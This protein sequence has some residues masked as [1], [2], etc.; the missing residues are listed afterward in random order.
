LRR[1]EIRGVFLFLALIIILRV[2]TSFAVPADNTSFEVRNVK[3]VGVNEVDKEELAKSLMAKVPSFW[4]FW[5]PHPVIQIK[6]LADDTLRIKQYYQAQGY[7]QATAEYTITN[8]LSPTG[9]SEPADAAKSPEPSPEL[10]PGK[11]N[12]SENDPVPEYDI[13]F[14]I[15]EGPVVT[16]RDIAI[17]CLCDSET[18]S[19]GQIMAE[20]PLKPGRIFKSEE[21]DQSKALIRKLLGNLAYPFAKVTGHATVDLNDNSVD[22]IF[23]ID[24]DKLYHFGDIRLTGYEDFVREEVLY[25]AITFKEGERFATKRIDESRRNLFDLNIFRTAVVKMGEPEIEKNIVPIDVVVKPRKKRSVKLGVG[26]GT[27]D[28]LR[29]QAGWT[30]RNLT[31][32]ADKLTLRARRSDIV[33]NIFAEYSVPYFLSA[34]NNLVAIAGYEREEKDYYTLKQ[35]S[36]EVNLYHKLDANWFASI[37][38]NLQNN[39]PEDVSVEDAEGEVDPRDAESY[40]VSSIKFGLKYSTVD[41]VLNSRKGKAVS[42]SFEN[43]SKYL[44]SEISFIRP[45][46]ETKWFIPLPWD[47]VLA[48][49]ADFKTIQESGDTDYIP[50]S[51]QFFLGG[52]KSVRGYGFE[53]LGVIDTNDVIL[54]VSGLSS[55][56]GN[57]ELRFPIYKNFGGVVFLDAGALYQ[58]SFKID[59]DSLRYTSGVGLRYNTIIG[60]IQIDY[61]YQLNPAKSTAYD[62]PDLI[63]LLNND[64]WYIHFNIGQTF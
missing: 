2:G 3:F 29:L 49:R 10:S 53:K 26:Y 24:P 58:N 44:G 13:L 16:I 5:K 4:K 47:M 36:T 12:G 37:G 54:D 19:D 45:G 60:P 7:Y 21:Y 23:E 34:R 41:D 11:Q 61:G 35:T 59:V 27:D 39:R 33:E 62:D 56:V 31:G 1:S 8:L 18:V 32:W 28:G 38:Y 20:F 43:A 57:V 14:Q 52:S 6:D 30:Y 48:L 9:S 25:R 40:H 51:E 50:I 17:N 55:L 22:I 64:R 15:K 42:F 46:I 63:D